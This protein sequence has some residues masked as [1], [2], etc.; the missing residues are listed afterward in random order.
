MATSTHTPC[1]LIIM[2]AASLL[3]FLAAVDGGMAAD[4]QLDKAELLMVSLQSPDTPL[5]VGERTSVD[6]RARYSQVPPGAELYVILVPMKEDDL[7]FDHGYKVGVSSTDLTFCSKF[8]KSEGGDFRIAAN[9]Y[10]ISMDLKVEEVLKALK[11]SLP[12]EQLDALIRRS[13]GKTITLTFGFIASLGQ[14]GNG[15]A[16]GT[17][18]FTPPAM[19]ERY[20]GILL[21]PYIFTFDE[22]RKRCLTY[23][24][25]RMH[26]LQY[27]LALR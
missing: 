8:V 16:A 6:L 11:D 24:S 15:Q 20:D 9:N 2:L 14:G 17:I 23:G 18:T 1:S 19:D 21:T 7:V 5:R 22:D 13:A 26:S 25:D 12:P 27:K 3:F 4:S 10:P